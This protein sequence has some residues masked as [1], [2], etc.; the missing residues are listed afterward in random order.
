V[1]IG[2]SGANVVFAG[3]TFDLSRLSGAFTFPVGVIADAALAV[4]YNRM[5]TGATGDLLYATGTAAG[6]VSRLA[7]VAAGSYLV[8]GGTS[9]APT[10]STLTLPNAATTGDL[11][12]ATGSN[13]MGRIT[14]V[15]TGS[16]LRSAG[17]S[18]LP[19]WSTLTIPNS[20]TQGDVIIATGANAL[21]S[22]ADVAAGSFLRSGGTST[23]PV[24]STTTWP[25][26]ATTG[27]IV[28]ASG[29]N[30]FAAISAV[31]SGQVLA[32]AGTSTLPAWTATPTLTSLTITEGT[33][34]QTGNVAAT[35]FSNTTAVP[36]VTSGIIDG[37]SY[38]MPANTL[39]SNG[40]MLV[41]HSYAI[42]AANT[43][44]ANFV[45]LSFNGVGVGSITSAVSNDT[46]STT[47]YLTRLTSSTAQYQCL[48]QSNAGIT[49][50]R[51]VFNSLNFAA[52]IVVKNTVT[53][54]TTNGDMIA[55]GL[56]VEWF[57]N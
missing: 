19:V 50:Q 5:S 42:H 55:N 44:S 31:A 7:D 20:A 14:A 51:G 53:G 11:F 10:W 13:A 54:A 24:W 35:S 9:S 28:A 2:N 56:R 43:N 26:A 47:C 29:S 27:D 33:G 46:I 17:T 23:A 21:G 57:P 1:S 49:S 12:A 25:N 8:S 6:G 34:S 41:V 40:Q 15:A 37:Q 36:S 3:T 4:T 32:S 45:S 38:T 16:F 48:A 52:S 18:T 39:S 22:L 30:A